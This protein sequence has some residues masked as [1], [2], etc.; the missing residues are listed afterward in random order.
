MRWKKLRGGIGALTTHLSQLLER[1]GGEV[2]LRSKVTEIVVDNSR[3][4]A[5][6][7]GVRTAAGTP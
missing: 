3:S 4:S 6:V 5:R 7:R 1:T 2:R